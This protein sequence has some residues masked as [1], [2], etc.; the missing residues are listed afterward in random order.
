MLFNNPSEYTNHEFLFPQRSKKLSNQRLIIFFTHTQRIIDFWIN[1]IPVL[2]MILTTMFLLILTLDFSKFLNNRFIGN[3][4][5]QMNRNLCNTVINS[6]RR[7]NAVWFDTTYVGTKLTYFLFATMCNNF[8]RS[9][10]GIKKSLSFFFIETSLKMIYFEFAST[11]I[12][13]LRIKV[14][15]Q[16]IW[17]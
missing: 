6:W 10:Q 2:I 8:W 17:Y 9:L 11:L 13:T 12:N 15:Y 4:S 5:L 1:R 16:E 3:N 7:V 14:V